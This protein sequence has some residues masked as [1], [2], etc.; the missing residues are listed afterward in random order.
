MGSQIVLVQVDDISMEIMGKKWPWPRSLF[1]RALSRIA[2]ENPAL[3]AFDFAFS[4]ATTQAEDGELKRAL[5][6]TSI[7]V[8]AGMGFYDRVSQEKTEGKE[9]LFVH[10]GVDLPY[11]EQML[12]GFLNIP[13]DEDGKIRRTRLFREHQGQLYLSFAARIYTE[14]KK[15][16]NPVRNNAE[17]RDVLIPAP[18]EEFLIINYAGPSGTFSTIS[19]YQVLGKDLLPPGFF[20]NKIV[21]VGPAFAAGQDEHFTPFWKYR[22]KRSKMP[23]VEIHAHILDTLLQEEFLRSSQ[24]SGFSFLF[25][26]C[27][28]L[29][30]ALALFFWPRG[31]RSFAVLATAGLVYLG[32]LLSVYFFGGR[33]WP[34]LPL[35]GLGLGGLV[36][37]IA[38]GWVRQKDLDLQVQNL[39]AVEEGFKLDHFLSGK[40]I[41]SREKEVLLMI[42]KDMTNPQI[43]KKL[44]ISL[45]TVKKHISNIYQ[46]LSVQSRQ[47][48]MDKI[49]QEKAKQS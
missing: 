2:S 6:G 45:F 11:F 3:I 25:W 24:G 49:A 26:L 44:Y 21:L 23:G 19:F 20:R 22:G 42:I 37:K 32:L 40:D 18:G 13:V 36:V 33:I 7:P 14:L 31:Y 48:L 46:K 8:V 16:D 28:W 47:E 43:S 15:L 5:S 10:S 27:L 17:P 4:G 39:S 1:A 9:A 41:T 35:I 34:I 12:P 29:P 30:W 38:G